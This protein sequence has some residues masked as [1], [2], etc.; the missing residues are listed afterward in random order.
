[1]GVDADQI[2]TLAWRV[3]GRVRTKKLEEGGGF[4]FLKGHL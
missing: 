3:E 1:M 2:E 4:E